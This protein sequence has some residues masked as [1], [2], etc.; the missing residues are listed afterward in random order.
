MG[1]PVPP[2]QQ[3][4]G[5]TTPDPDQV[6]GHVFG[7][8]LNGL[9]GSH[10]E[11]AIDPNTGQ[12]VSTKVKETPGQTFR[13]ILAYGLLGA[14]GI[15]NKEGE[16][17]FTQG[18]LSGLG[19][20]VKASQ[21]GQ[22]KLDQQRRAEAQQQYANQ[23]KANEEAREN[24]KLSLQEQLNQ[25]Q[26][27]NYNQ[28]KVLREQTFQKQAYDFGKEKAMDVAAPL[29]HASEMQI[30]AD[31]LE[32]QGHQELNVDP[33]AKNITEEEG[34][35]LLGNNAS[36]SVK[37]TF[38]H[39]DTDVSYDPNTG[40]ATVTPLFTVYPAASKVSPSLVEG[41]K[42]VASDPKNRLN[43]MY[44]S[45]ET[46]QKAGTTVPFGQIHS[47]YKELQDYEKIQ[48]DSLAIQTERSEIR[49]RDAEAAEHNIVAQYQ[50]FHFKSEEDAEEGT[51]LLKEHFDLVDNVLMNNQSIGLDAK[52]NPIDLTGVNPTTNKPY[53]A[54]EINDIHTKQEQLGKALD[55]LYFQKLDKYVSLSPK[56]AD[57]GGVTAD[58][59]EQINIL[60]AE[61]SGLAFA[62]NKL[63][64]GNAVPL[65]PMAKQ[66]F[67]RIS[68]TGVTDP[69]QIQAQFDKA[70]VPENVRLEV[71]RKLGVKNPPA[72]SESGST[73]SELP[74][75]RA[76]Q[77]VQWIA[78]HTSPP[79]TNILPAP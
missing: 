11:Y 55:G 4:T 31:K 15:G 47:A 1:T 26:I 33:L 75:T 9:S 6:K 45:L 30:A 28:E 52:G 29:L 7:K 24:K 62:K 73:T 44:K 32:V 2:P 66:I 13:S 69:A 60:G 19:G 49:A 27:A 58:N 18:L 43:A 71:W 74:P 70:G 57:E 20:G 53:T 65:S 67:G 59:R 5:Q 78:D 50:K 25:V 39:T 79:T 56:A 77:G 64:G 10:N 54:S 17:T 38:L 41:L 21:E 63:L 8:L 42:A 3:Q 40:K 68:S 34:N 76:E 37:Y 51:N 48:K 22:E 72:S 12:T 14:Q 36:H 46:A 16:H 35:K 61:L 23:L